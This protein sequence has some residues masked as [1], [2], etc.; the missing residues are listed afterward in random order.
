MTEK[1]N[2]DNYGWK[3]AEPG[4]EYSFDGPAILSIC[5]EKGFKKILDVGCGNGALCRL[6][7]SE[8]FEVMGCDADAEGVRLASGSGFGMEFK[9]VGVYDDPALI[10]QKNFDVIVSSQV[11]EH[12]FI[13]SALPKFAYALLKP[14]G[15]LIVTTPYHGYIKNLVLSILN[16]WDSHHTLFWDGGHIKFWSIKT[17]KE[18][19]EKE[20]FEFS[21]FKGIGRVPFLW[22][23]MLMVFQKKNDDTN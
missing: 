19:V 23:S 9:K 10:G 12:L 21:K 8:G 16:L 5:K 2:V 22:K 11:V 4:G 6:L 7:K 15:C 3:N 14:G 20:G 18:L 1:R 13:P 17:L